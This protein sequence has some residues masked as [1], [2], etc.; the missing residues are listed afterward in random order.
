MSS[1]GSILS[2]WVPTLLHLRETEHPSWLLEHPKMRLFDIWSCYLARAG[3]RLKK[4]RKQRPPCALLELPVEVILLIGDQL[5]Q[6]SHLVLAQTCRPLQVAVHVYLHRG[7]LRLSHDEHLDYLA[8]LARDLPDKWVCEHCVK[9]HQVA[10]N[11][12]P[13]ADC[14]HPMIPCKRHLPSIGFWTESTPYELYHRHVQLALK[15]IRAGDDLDARYRSYLK[16]LLEPIEDV[17]YSDTKNVLPIKFS[18]SPRVVGG[19]FLL[20]STWR[21]DRAEQTSL[22]RDP[23]WLRD[24]LGFLILCRHQSVRW[25]VLFSV[26]NPR[27]YYRRLRL[28]DIMRTMACAFEAPDGIELD[29]AC[30]CCRTDFAAEASPERVILRVWQ[31]LGTEGSPTD[32]MWQ[33]FASHTKKVVV[34][35][36][37]GS[38]R[39]LFE[40]GE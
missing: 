1:L 14:Y 25:D 21:Y 16:G 13:H 38:V 23:S 2:P 26:E 39:E 34:E 6:Q 32:A 30:S 3:R 36:K 22:S 5:P 19:R 12:G 29:G 37:P 31:D 24:S 15:Y 4:S 40:S 33:S 7:G 9:L 20:L 28:S 18:A 11:D 17:S 8:C 35:H 10:F 27:G